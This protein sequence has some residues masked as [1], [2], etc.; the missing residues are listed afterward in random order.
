MSALIK[1]EQYADDINKFIMR[2]CG[3]NTQIGNETI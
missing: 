3:V 2:V 1:S